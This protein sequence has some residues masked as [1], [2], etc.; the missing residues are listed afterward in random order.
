MQSPLPIPHSDPLHQNHYFEKKD[1]VIYFKKF[2]GIRN[3]DKESVISFVKQF[4]TKKQIEHKL[5]QICLYDNY[6]DSDD[7]ENVLSNSWYK[8][9]TIVEDGES[10]FKDILK[11]NVQS[12]FSKCVAYSILENDDCHIIGKDYNKLACICTVVIERHT[13]IIDNKTEIHFDSIGY[14]DDDFEYNILTLVSKQSESEFEKQI[15]NICSQCETL[16][17]ILNKKNIKTET[18]R[19][20]IVEY[21][22]RNR[23]E[24]Y[25][26]LLKSGIVPNLD[27]T[28]NG[29]NNKEKETY[30]IGTIDDEPYIKGYTLDARQW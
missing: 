22:F 30:A 8:Q 6:F 17:K 19:R 5:K 25:N 28:H 1:S 23:E 14:E 18:V 9:R 10:D 12:P 2:L 13:A 26:K 3:D 21:L 4:Q 11:C 20:P 24:T 15:G 16:E 27:Y 7:F 29:K